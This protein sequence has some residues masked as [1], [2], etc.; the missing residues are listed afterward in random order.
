MRYAFEVL[1]PVSPDRVDEN[2]ARLTAAIVLVL[3]IAGL[4]FRS[5]WV[6]IGLGLDFALR[7][8]GYARYSPL[9]SA[10]QW[11]ARALSLSPRPT[12]AA[13]KRFAAGVGLLFSVSIAFA[14]LF[15][16]YVSGLFIGVV[17]AACA[18]LESVL[19]F[20]VGCYVYTFLL[21]RWI[22]RFRSGGI[23]GEEIVPYHQK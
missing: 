8:F 1:C 4:V 12:D 23:A 16:W 3:T 2:I 13:P 10:A 5:P 7:A 15:H 17:L 22:P 6:M 14:F 9:R 19:N 18:A 20:C 21:G 11:M